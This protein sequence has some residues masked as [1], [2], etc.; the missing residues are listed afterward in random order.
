MSELAK[1]FENKNDDY[2]KRVQAKV[3]GYDENTGNAVCQIVGSNQKHTYINKS[4]EMLTAGDSVQI[5]YFTSIDAGFVG[6]RCGTNKVLQEVVQ[7]MPNMMKR[8]KATV[9]S[10]NSETTKGIVKFEGID[11]TYELWNKTGLELAENDDVDVWYFKENYSDAFI[12]YI[13]KASNRLNLIEKRLQVIEEQLGITETE[14][15]NESN[16]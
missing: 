11:N 3:L 9:V 5:W 12:A 7:S 8:I 13:D 6:L 10:Y 2:L 16:T 15:S 14:D 4:G 1:L